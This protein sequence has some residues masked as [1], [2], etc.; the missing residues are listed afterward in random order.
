MDADGGGREA[1]EA[2]PDPEALYLESRRLYKHWKASQPDPGS[3]LLAGED[4]AD[5]GAGGLLA[6]TTLNRWTPAQLRDGRRARADEADAGVRGAASLRMGRVRPPRRERGDEAW[7]PPSQDVDAR[8][9]REGQARAQDG[10]NP[11]RLGPRGH[12]L[13]T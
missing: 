12:Q 11:L 3:D 2:F 4:G 8:E 13:G 10:G 5:S 7:Q 1:L 6:A 9:H